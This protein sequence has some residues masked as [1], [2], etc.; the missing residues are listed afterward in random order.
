MRL[1]VNALRAVRSGDR[2]IGAVPLFGRP[3]TTGITGNE[4]IG[5]ALG[6]LDMGSPI[7][8]RDRAVRLGAALALV[9]PIGLERELKGEPGGSRRR[10]RVSL[11]SRLSMASTCP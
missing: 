9:F 1:A 6:S 2:R 7:P 5:M 4:D 8:P 3:G 11:G 10:M